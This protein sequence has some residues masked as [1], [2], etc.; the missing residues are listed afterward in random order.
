MI[1]DLKISVVLYRMYAMLY[2]R[3]EKY[4][5]SLVIPQ[6]SG[7]QNATVSLRLEFMVCGTTRDLVSL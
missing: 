5:V 1:V 2:P 7:A 3:E 6:T 4:V